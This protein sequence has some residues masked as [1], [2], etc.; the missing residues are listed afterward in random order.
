MF[1]H[2]CQSELKNCT[3]DDLEDRL[4]KAV[5]LGHFDYNKCLMCGKHYARCKCKNQQLILA[6]VYNT[7]DKNKF[8]GA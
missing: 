7:L 6:S 2:N 4:D 5:S 8:K 1:C 3:C